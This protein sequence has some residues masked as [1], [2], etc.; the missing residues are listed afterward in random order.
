MNKLIIMSLLL[1]M[2]SVCHA[3]DITIRY[4]GTT[5]K[6]DQK[7]K[8]SV[9]VT[10][11]G[12]N[13]EIESLYKSH[14]LTLLLTGKSDDG[15]L[16]LK[17]AGK[18][19]VKL[20]NLTLTSQEGAPLWLKNKKKVEVV[21][22]K[23]TKNTL[24]ITA[25][26]DTANHK[27]AT[28]WA[29]DKLL[30]SGK[31][32]LNVIATGDGCR[33]IKSKKDITIEELTLN[34]TTSGN[35]L[36][37]KPFGF[38]DFPGFGNGSTMQGG[39]PMPPF[40]ND[41]IKLGNFPM[42]NFGGQMPNFGGQ[43]PNFGGQMPD[44]GG[45]MPDFGG[46]FPPFGNDSTMQE[47]M[48]GFMG[49]HKYVASTKGI[50]SKGKITINSG[51]VTVRTSTPGAEGIEGKQ[52]VV[53][54][55]GQVDV[56]ATDDAVNANATIAFNG[57]HVTARSTTNDAVDSN[58][59]TGFFT[60][61]G[62]NNNTNSQEADTAI[63]IRGGTVYA[64]SQVGS[65]EEGLDCDFSPLV[66]EGGSIFSVGGGMGEMPS[67]PTNATAKQPTVL[68][69]GLNITKDEPITICDANGKCIDTI[70]IPFSL[71]RSASLVTSPSF[72]PGN[73]YTVKT[74]GYEKT[75]TLNEPFTT[76]R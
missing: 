30:L 56:L 38:G 12:A 41:S 20:D 28:I 76:I 10:V 50:A 23:G 43:M 60:P 33:G 6:V 54:N 31:G 1:V 48:G 57:A 2:G 42:P 69:I 22:A 11:S 16:V 25:C 37:E 61:F 63:V 75:F 62:G 5:A 29:K 18:A 59:K 71:R 73:T 64:W 4:K 67:V 53:F 51:V 27:A 17:T 8:D 39:F 24:T 9:N 70:T 55:G 44:F 3:E 13:V 45:Q 40:G 21:A 34:V 72:R 68:L 26:N 15:Q 74:K 52:G 58:P 66:I 7:V 49:K 47:G 65:P 35:N 46:G 14:R 19:K 32:T 36:G